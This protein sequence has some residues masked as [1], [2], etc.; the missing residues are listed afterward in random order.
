MP[1]PRVPPARRT[2][3]SRSWRQ[4]RRLRAACGGARMRVG[5]RPAAARCAPVSK[6]HECR[7]RCPTRLR[8]PPCA[9]APVGTPAAGPAGARAPLSQQHHAVRILQQPVSL[10]RRSALDVRPQQSRVI[11]RAQRLP[12]ACRAAARG[13]LRLR[14]RHGTRAGRP[15]PL[16]KPRSG[17]SPT[18]ATA[19][20]GHGGGRVGDGWGGGGVMRWGP[21]RRRGCGRAHE[22]LR[23]TGGALRRGSHECTRP[24]ATA[25]RSRSLFIVY[26]A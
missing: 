22:H 17:G 21:R 26:D 8:R 15:R 6:G 4:P 18:R 3:A 5:L 9:W 23:R 25:R 12:A 19:C 7:A 14:L 2:A 10:V 13:R 11:A 24:P 1:A 16:T 20:L